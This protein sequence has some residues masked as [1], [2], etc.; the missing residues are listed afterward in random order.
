HAQPYER[1]EDRQ[2]FA[3]GFK[4]KTV[5]TRIGELHLDIP[6]VRDSDFYPKAMEKGIRSERALKVALGEMDMQ[7][8]ATRKVAAVLEQLCGTDISS[9]QVSDATKLVDAEFGKWR[10]RRIGEIPY[11]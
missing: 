10:N 7:G 2:G 9:Q 6:Q 4:P 8:V 5:K 1:T 11:L 3:N